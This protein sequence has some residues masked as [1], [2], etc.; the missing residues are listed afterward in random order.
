MQTKITLAIAT[1]VRAARAT[2]ADNTII[3]IVT[4]IIISCRIRI[5]I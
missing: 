1:T 3:I 2:G 4:I 5:C